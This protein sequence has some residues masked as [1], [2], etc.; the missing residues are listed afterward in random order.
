[1]VHISKH[2]HTWN[3]IHVAVVHGMEMLGTIT[4][5]KNASC[6]YPCPCGNFNSDKSCTCSLQTVTRYQKRISG[7]MLD[8]I[9]IHIEVPRVDF[10]K[11][12]DNRR[13]ESSDDIRARVEAAREIQRQRFN[14]LENGVMTN[15]DMRVAEIRQFCGLDESGQQLIKAAMTQLQLSARAYHRILKLARTIADLAGEEHI[16]SAHLAEALQYRPKGMMV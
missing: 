12:S 5:K 15:A 1:M 14:G 16:Q 11:L 10:E 13:G 4:V 9:D 3:E 6:V 7:P 8:R 2:A